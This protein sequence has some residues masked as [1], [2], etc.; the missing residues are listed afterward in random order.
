MKK[1]MRWFVAASVSVV[2]M[3]GQAAGADLPGA[4]GATS[5]F[6]AATGLSQLADGKAAGA[7][8]A[9]QALDGLGGQAAKLVLVFH[10]SKGTGSLEGVTSVFDAAIVCGG[11]SYDPITEHG[12]KGNV[13]VLAIAGQV[14]VSTAFSPNE[15]G[16]K[17]CGMAIGESLKAA[18][19]RE[20]KGRL[21]VLFGD[22]HVPQN[23]ELIKGVQ[24]V[25][26]D[27]LLIVGG[28]AHAPYY[29]RGKAL[30]AQKPNMGALISGPFSVG[31]ATRSDQSSPE[32]CIACGE[33]AVRTAVGDHQAR[34]AMVFTM[35]CGGRR[36]TMK[37]DIDKE[38]AG[39]K[40]AAGNVP[41][42][43][44]YGSGEIGHADAGAPAKG[45]G[46]SIVAGAIITE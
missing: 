12:N 10:N 29:Y 34:T 37:N 16:F 45:V 3:A 30:T 11:A 38:L 13:G 4:K 2:T 33:A 41:I 1:S 35:N 44:F 20:A 21:L 27:R 23:D 7:E 14:E 31:V 24:S 18:A 6:K 9:R 28:A 15:N 36:G 22:C 43:G 19:S 42:F 32:A 39:M 25:L 40:K 17:A 26:G 46:Y 8:A 5:A